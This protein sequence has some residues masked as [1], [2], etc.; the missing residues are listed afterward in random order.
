MVDL[1]KIFNSDGFQDIADATTS[2]NPT[3]HDWQVYMY[4]QYNG[5]RDFIASTAPAF[6]PGS[7]G[8]FGFTIPDTTVAVVGDRLIK[9]CSAAPDW[10]CRL[11]VV[12]DTAAAMALLLMSTPVAVNETPTNPGPVAVNMNR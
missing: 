6:T 9:V 5:T 3:R 11:A 7:F 12:P 8:G 1:A 10:I 2:T 4:D